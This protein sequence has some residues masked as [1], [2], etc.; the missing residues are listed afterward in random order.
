MDIT[1]RLSSGGAS[2]ESLNAL[3]TQLGC[4]LPRDYRDFLETHNGG[5]PSPRAFRFVT[6]QGHEESAVQFFFT[7]DSTGKPY[8]IWDAVCVYKDRI[9]EGLLPVACDSFGNL[10][11]LDLGAR[12][13]G[14]VYFWDHEKESM[15]DVTWDNISPIAP[16]FADFVEGL[17]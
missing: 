1:E 17:L 15:D 2:Q 7:T 5:R 16:S 14:S 3:E 10:V 12:N 13:A 4:R 11:L 9:P 6:P 8:V